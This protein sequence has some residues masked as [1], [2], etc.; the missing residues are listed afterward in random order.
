MVSL[1]VRF[2]T[3]RRRW[4]AAPVRRRRR[5]PR[6]HAVTG[7]VRDT[8]GAALPGVDGHGHQ[9]GHRRHPDGDHRHRRK[10]LGHRA[11][12]RVHGRGVAARASA[13]RPAATSSRRRRRTGRLH[14][15]GRARGG[16][17]GHGHAARADRWPTCPSPSPRPPRRS[18]ASA[19]S[20]TS[21]TWP[22]TWPASPCRTSAPARARSPCA[23]CP[24]GQ[25]VRDQPGVKEQVGAY[26]DD[27]IISLSLFTPDLDLF[28]VARV[29]VLR[30]PQGTLFGA[31]SLSGTVRY[32]SNQPELGRDEVLRRGRRAARS[33]AAAP[34]A[35]PSSA[36]T[37]PLGDTAAVRVAAYY[38][39]MPRL[40]RRRAARTSA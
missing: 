3:S 14:P 30:G 35:T 37:C 5:T 33:T 29:E 18:C 23:A 16:G 27:S 32:I 25:I 26:L 1:R 24:P 22:R 9:P 7:V 8:T 21:R 13:G 40:H 38:N 31:G 34:A 2:L 12:R 36:S 17:H 11:A 28:D 15:R 10:L 4:P 20:T 19:A 39:H 6:T